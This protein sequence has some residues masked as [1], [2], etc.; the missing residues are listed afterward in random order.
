MYL[1]HHCAVSR[2]RGLDSALHQPALPLPPALALAL[3]VQTQQRRQV[4]EEFRI[5]K[6]FL[7]VVF[8]AKYQ[9]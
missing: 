3:L 4:Q 1:S 6:K 8:V 5:E 7:C 9:V 2:G